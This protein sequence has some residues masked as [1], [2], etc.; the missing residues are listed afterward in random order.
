MRAVLFHGKDERIH[1]P[2]DNQAGGFH[3]D[4]FHRP[5][6]PHGFPGFHEPKHKRA[7]PFQRNEAEFD[8]AAPHQV[9]PVDHHEWVDGVVGQGVGLEFLGVTLRRIQALGVTDKELLL[10]RV[11]GVG[12]NLD[13]A[14]DL[15]LEFLHLKGDEPAGFIHNLFHGSNGAVG[16]EKFPLDV[17]GGVGAGGRPPEGVE[18]LFLSRPDFVK[19]AGEQFGFGVIKR[20]ERRRGRGVGG[21]ARE[22]DGQPQQDRH[23]P[24]CSRNNADRKCFHRF[25][26]RPQTIT[27][28]IPQRSRSRNFNH[29]THERHER[30]GGTGIS[31]AKNAENSKKPST[32]NL[33]EM[34][35]AGINS[36]SFRERVDQKG[37]SDQVL[38][39]VTSGRWQ[40]TRI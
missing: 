39:N 6:V 9:V 21:K 35:H 18:N 8:G 13:G 36:E 7:L 23:N 14:G 3:P 40:V 30:S 31:T 32:L 12:R 34:R 10:L 37:G 19:G 17:D 11:F 1:Q 27:D 4:L 20:F 2:G 28:L 24:A 22:D 26:I 29:E 15:G 25:Q 16:A 33:H 38:F 5:A